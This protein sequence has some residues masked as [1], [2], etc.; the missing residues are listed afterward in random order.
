MKHRIIAASKTVSSAPTTVTRGALSCLVGVETMSSI[1]SSS[2]S[3]S[4]PLS[5]SIDPGESGSDDEG[6][7][8]DSDDA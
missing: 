4:E 5:V 6:E 8:D 7:K 2:S 3:S 1:S